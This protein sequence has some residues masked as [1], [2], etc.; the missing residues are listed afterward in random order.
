MNF[1]SLILWVCVCP[2]KGAVFVDVNAHSIV[3][4]CRYALKNASVL[5]GQAQDLSIE[6]QYRW[7]AQGAE[8]SC[9][10]GLLSVPSRPIDDQRLMEP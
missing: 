4:G 5:A 2:D 10:L 1:K 3:E 6:R 7:E 8:L 9:A